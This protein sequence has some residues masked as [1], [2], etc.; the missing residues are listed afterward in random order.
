MK[1]FLDKNDTKGVKKRETE[2]IDQVLQQM[3]HW[4][5]TAISNYSHQDIPWR[6]SKEGE[7]INY[8]LVFYREAPFSVRNYGDEV[9]AP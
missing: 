1:G 5:A 6:V 9:E 3:S 4:S 8:E 7:E 2:I